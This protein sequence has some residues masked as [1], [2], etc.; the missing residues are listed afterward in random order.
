MRKLA[1][2]DAFALHSRPVNMLLEQLKKF[3]S[4][5]NLSRESGLY[6]QGELNGPQCDV[7]GVCL[8]E[9]I[10]SGARFRQNSEKE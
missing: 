5:L 10:F 8:D 2:L 3:Y 7:S 4:R 1:D 9:L 6:G